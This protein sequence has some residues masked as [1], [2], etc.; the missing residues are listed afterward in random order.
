MRPDLCQEVHQAY[1][2][3]GAD[4]IITH[5]YS[6]NGNVMAA[7]GN[8]GRVDECI[9]CS[10]AIARRAALNHVAEYAAQVA[11]DAATAAAAAASAVSAAA[12]AAARATTSLHSNAAAAVSATGCLKSTQVAAETMSAALHVM[13]E[14]H[15]HAAAAKAAAAAA[16]AASEGRPLPEATPPIEQPMPVRTKGWDSAGFGPAMIVGS[17]STHPPEMT[18]GGESSCDAKWPL[19]EIEERNYFQAARAISLSGVD[20]LFLEMMKD[21]E[22]APRAV[23]AAASTG[24][25]VFLGLSMRTDK[26]TGQL[27]KWSNGVDSRPVDADWFHDLSRILGDNMVG[28]NV[29]HTD[30]STM[31]PAL[32]FIRET[33]GWQGPLGAYPD[34][35]RF[36]APEWIFEELNTEEALDYVK[37]WVRNYDVQL[38]GG[39]CGLGPE[40]ITALSAYT[41]RHN[42]EVR[43]KRKD[44]ADA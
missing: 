5:S 29:M 16:L 18:E 27:V 28:V 4:V 3:S 6:A 38:I 35:G 40:Y 22:H 14:V 21:S 41:R 34:H 30:F 31:G 12:T 44:V 8:G 43:Q 9:M 7:S 32:K 39:C 36:A 42:T 25:P 17:L 26:E 19:P 2:E 13:E 33:C 20:M 37:S 15:A 1:L 24:L 23:R 10:S 11:Q